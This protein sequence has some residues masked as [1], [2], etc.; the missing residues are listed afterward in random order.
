M[1]RIQIPDNQ[2]L[3]KSADYVRAPSQ[4]D[5]SP[6][7]PALVVIY[8]V[9]R[10]VIWANVERCSLSLLTLSTPYAF[11]CRTCGLKKLDER[12]FV[13]DPEWCAVTFSGRPINTKD[14]LLSADRCV[15]CG[16]EWIRKI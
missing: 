14:I 10:L 12:V 1:R 13:E 8:F 7:D 2:I 9:N 3:R 5:Y 6:S 4:Q 16:G 15:Y 11:T